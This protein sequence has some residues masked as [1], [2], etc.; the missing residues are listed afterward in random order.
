MLSNYFTAAQR[1][2]RKNK[3]FSLINIV[4]LSVGMA[5]TLLIG[6]WIW[7]EVSFDRS[8]QNY[9]KIAQVMQN[10]QM[11]GE[12]M[13]WPVLPHPLADA[14]RSGYGND[15][16]LVVRASWNE[17]HVLSVGDKTLTRDGTFFE[18]QGPELLDLTMLKGSRDALKD[19][20]AILLSGSLAKTLFGDADP[21][22]RG[23]VMDGKTNMKVAGVYADLPH[24]S[25]FADVSYIVPWEMYLAINPYI[26]QMQNPWG[27]NSFLL[28]VEVADHSNMQELS[29]RIRDLKL[30]NVHP[31]ERK[32]KPAL[33]LHPVSKWHLYSD[34]HNGINTG[35][36]IQYLW[37]FGIIGSFVLLLA[38]INFMNLS[39]A[40]SE[41][42]AKEVGIRKAIGSLRTQLIGQFYSESLLMALLAFILAIGIALPALPFFNAIADKQISLPWTSP[43]FWLAGI[44][45]SIFTG[46]I[47]GSYPALYL[48]S[49]KPVEVLK[50]TT[51]FR[52]GR[53]ATLP[54]K[55][56]VVLQF[57]VSVILAIG[58]IV[59]FRQIQFAKNRPIGYDR[60]GLISVQLLSPGIHEHFQAIKDQLLREGAIT[61]MA[62]SFGPLTNNWST[63]GGISWKGKDPNL[64]VD[65]PN[66]SVSYDFGKTAGWQFTQ[67]RDFSRDFAA[68]SDAF[69]INEAAAEYM[70]FK[71]PIGQVI[72]W[73]DRRPMSVIGVIKNVIAESPYA[74][75]RPTL[76]YMST[77]TANFELFRLNP[78]SGTG[79]A[80][81]K[82]EAVFKT[83]SP[84]QP[85]NYTF[86]DEEYAKKFGD[87]QRVSK[88]ATAFSILAVFISCLGLFGIATFIAEQRT[89]EIGVRKILGA[90]VIN[91]WGL[92][93]KEFLILV[94][95]SLLIATPAA[96]YCMSS[97]LRNY[98]YHPTMPWWIFTSAGAG[99]LLISLATVSYHSI[100]AARSNPVKSL[101]SE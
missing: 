23:I 44:G 92:M 1:N 9:Q 77:N 61:Q 84:R 97:W 71:N 94:A 28:Y 3:F 73:D 4:G 54:R 12:T 14:I 45:F 39:T 68:D 20:D 72:H 11:N 7:D 58:T 33:F 87:E 99:A 65:F 55:A 35:G 10:G 60:S 5:I 47:A 26:K 78:A 49:F 8:N 82:I 16:P 67:G 17:I 62:E 37:L 6:L 90:S 43:F 89:K 101:R 85:F 29:A 51:K 40:R 69:I 100:R 66:S 76:Y 21:M 57:T 74:P 42:R 22:G 96:W 81:A 79:D 56:L 70:N 88:L 38:C 98:P 19:P 75:V 32:S 64:A 80:L 18:P 48:S 41:R 30:K 95:I 15:F 31:D 34:F 46:I 53:S 25:S 63:S 83:Y 36:R 50:G 91:L 59:V 93:N 86:A 27:N 2:L 24:N 13:T 52:A